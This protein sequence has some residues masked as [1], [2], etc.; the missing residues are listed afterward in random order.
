MNIDVIA[1]LFTVICGKHGRYS[2]PKF[3]ISYGVGVGPVVHALPWEMFPIRAK[4]VASL[5]LGVR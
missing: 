4:G 1:P 2:E 3:L 5:V